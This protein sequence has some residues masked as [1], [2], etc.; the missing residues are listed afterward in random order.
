M[1]KIAGIVTICL[2]FLAVLGLAQTPEGGQAA[3]DLAKATQNPVSNIISIPFQF[4]FNSGGGLGDKTFFNLNF[5]PVI[6]FKVTDGLN[7]IARTIVPIVSVPAGDARFSGIGDI[8][9]QLFFA[10]SKA[11][12]TVVGIG[13]I[14]S[15]PTATAD[16][17]RTGSW[18]A[19][20]NG[21]VVKTTKHF[22]LGALINQLW[23]FADDGDDVKVNQFLLQPF[24]N[25]NF[26][27]GWALT[28][29]PS[30]TANWDAPDGEQWTVPVGM[31]IARTTV[32]AKRPMTLA[33]AYYHNVEHPSGAAANQLRIQVT[34]IYPGGH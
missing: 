32:F 15:F 12:S 13:P 10:S 30:I 26:G 33:I 1:K 11:T 23:T 4:N 27:K 34:L 22:V 21:V 16:V 9:E 14:F 20:P 8:Q 18:A 28:T 24:V 17:S 7:L 29:G 31:G 3:S 25:F 5:Q 19:G 2:C 6:P